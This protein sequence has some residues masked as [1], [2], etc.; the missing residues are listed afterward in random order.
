MKK[1]K[2]IA[3]AGVTLIAAATLAACG[4]SS[5]SNSS[6]SKTYSYIY[7]TDPDTLDY[8]VSN[9]QTTSDLTANFI[10]GLF[11]NDQYGNLVP[12]MAED[13]T[14]SA[15]GL[16]YTYKIRKDAKWYTS[17]GE[18]YA[19]VK[20]Q[21]F[22][23][24]LQ[25]A[26]DKKSESA[27]L[28][29]DSIKG[30]ADYVNGKTKDFSSVGVK[31]VDDHTLQYT[32]NQPESYWNSKLT[33]S[34]MMPVN[35]D[36]LKSKGDDFGKV[37]P[38]SILYNGPY[39]LKAYT[40]KSSLEYAK[41]EN[42]WD[43]DNVKIDS[44]KLAYSDGSDPE[45]YARN[46]SDGAYTQAR[47]Y[48]NTS[49]FSSVEKQYKDNIVYAPQDG[50]TFYYQFNLDRKAES[51]TAKTTDAQKNAT[52]QAIL[53]KD[54]RQ[55][56]NFALDRTNFVAQSNGQ[57][58]ANRS[59]R[60]SL[61]PPTFVQVGD[62]TFGQ[63][64][65]KD[66]VSY[67]DE[68][69]DVKLDDAQ[70]GL[71]NPDKAKAEF[72]KAKET[73]QGQGVQFPIHLDVPVP[74]TDKN[75][76]NQAQSLKQSVEN[77]LGKDNVVIDVLQMSEQ[78]QE[79]ITYFADTASQKD[80]DLHISGWGP[81]YQDPSTY[82]DILNPDNGSILSNIGLEAGK[83]QEVVN[84]VGLNDYKKLIEDAGAEKSDV[85][86][87]YTK[88]AAAQAW[89]TDSSILLPVRS[90]GGNPLLSKVTPFTKG[91]S[92]VG[93]KGDANVFKYMEVQS[94]IVKASDY[95][96]AL[97]KWQ[98]DMQSSQEKAQADLEKHVAK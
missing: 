73:L 58:G 78:E 44:V 29:Q 93:V 52:K 82:L 86:A 14:V 55:A 38:D 94:D 64:V 87:R 26:I 49:S 7:L 77:T 48:P 51:H 97:K 42:Y 61:V 2:I 98:T 53:N 10:D 50:S 88:Y 57:T 12:S 54:F 90:N 16:T 41:N 24:G 80:Y 84:A 18:E 75:L 6:A 13:W 66:L 31:A 63:V 32:L 3:L 91:Y 33:A 19:D 25:H 92:L 79:N 17:D 68:W 20:A 39:L 40:A 11:E 83:D 81:D 76:V 47:L 4:S 5:S 23:T 46:F 37:T 85:T 35:A 95:E 65:Q 67:G 15:D 62:Q 34:I 28:V 8:V 21:D 60:N 43:K 9:R 89:L 96:K 71:Y 72:A 27:Y 56:I 1:S 36:F 59:L 45:S 30:L 69:K 74:Q 70:D 22:V